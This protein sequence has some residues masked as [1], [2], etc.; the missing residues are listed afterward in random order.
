MGQSNGV[1]LKV[2]AYQRC[3]LVKGSTVHTYI[4]LYIHTPVHGCGVHWEEEP[5]TSSFTQNTQ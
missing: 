3:P 2:A 4:H 5:H 1:L